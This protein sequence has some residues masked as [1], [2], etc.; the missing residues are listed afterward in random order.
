MPCVSPA[1]QLYQF[2]M[3]GQLNYPPYQ[4]VYWSTYNVPD[5]TG[6]FSGYFGRL[7]NIAILSVSD[8]ELGQQVNSPTGPALG[9]LCG[10]YPNPTV[11][12]L[13][14]YWLPTLSDGY[15]NWTGSAWAL[16]PVSSGST[17]TI[18]PQYTTANVPVSQAVITMGAGV[19]TLTSAQY[20]QAVLQIT[21]NMTSNIAIV[22][23]MLH[24][25]QWTIDH[26]TVN[27]NTHQLTL[28]IQGGY[29][30]GTVIPYPGVTKVTCG[31]SGHFY[32]ATNT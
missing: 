23:P 9:D 3:S 15:L 24:D 31:L 22:F 8:V 13:D 7:E 5:M 19:L 21:G 29:A 1:T 6:Q 10:V 17:G 11:V 12:G 16:S 28:A 26:S 25:Y 32:G 4:L 20:S 30:W 2:N 27:F 18:P 14:G